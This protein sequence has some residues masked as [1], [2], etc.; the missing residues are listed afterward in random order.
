MSHWQSLG[1]LLGDSLSSQILLQHTSPISSLILSG[2]ICCPPPPP[3]TTLLM[4]AEVV[5]LN[6]D[7]LMFPAKSIPYK[8]S[9]N[10]VPNAG[11]V[12]KF[13]VPEEQLLIVLLE[14]PSNIPP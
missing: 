3:V 12:L 8:L 2:V 1:Q 11:V 5:K 14:E 10:V 9:M 6:N 13:S 4:D 7:E